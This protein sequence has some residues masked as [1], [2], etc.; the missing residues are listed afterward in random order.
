MSGKEQRYVLDDLV[1]VTINMRGARSWFDFLLTKEAYETLIDEACG[2]WEFVCIGQQQENNVSVTQIR[3][4]AIET[5]RAELYS[6]WAVTPAENNDPR[7]C[8]E[9]IAARA[10]AITHHNIRGTARWSSRIP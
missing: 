2:K 5:I 1:Q 10:H 3:V 4:E 7:T 6:F 8:V 9:A